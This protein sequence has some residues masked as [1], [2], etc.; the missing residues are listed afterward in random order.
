ME[1][2]HQESCTSDHLAQSASWTGCVM[3]SSV[4]VLVNSHSPEPVPLLMSVL[5]SFVFAPAI[6]QWAQP[7]CTQL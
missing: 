4:M 6:V 3:V 2:Y 5:R 7:G 1:V